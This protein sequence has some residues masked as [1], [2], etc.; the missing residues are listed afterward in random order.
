MKSAL[1]V[2]VL[3]LWVSTVTAQVRDIGCLS[4]CPYGRVPGSCNCNPPPP[5]ADR[6]ACMIECP[7]NEL[8][9]GKCQCKLPVGN[10]QQQGEISCMLDCGL[11]GVVPG[12]CKC[13][14]PSTL[15]QQNYP[16]S[17]PCSYMKCATFQQ[18]HVINGRGLCIL[19]LFPTLN[20]WVRDNGNTNVI[21]SRCDQPRVSGNCRGFLNRYYY[22]SRTGRCNRF[23]YS[24]C[25][26]NQ[27]NFRTLRACLTSCSGH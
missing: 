23:V 13:A 11:N 4:Q 1:I 26:A 27:N 25:G 6:I 15:I 8:V 21:T 5:N 24:G 18:C 20:S 22:D 19:S 12:Q 9:P 14:E 7:N 2:S 10:I 16:S 3:S 17:N